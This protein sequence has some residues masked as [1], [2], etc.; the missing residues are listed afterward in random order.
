MQIIVS[1]HYRSDCFHG[2]LIGVNVV[3]MENTNQKGMFRKINL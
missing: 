2:V 1:N 3:R